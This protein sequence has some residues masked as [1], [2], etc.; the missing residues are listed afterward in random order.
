LAS[1]LSQGEARKLDW[2]SGPGAPML[3]DKATSGRCAVVGDGMAGRFCDVNRGDLGPIETRRLGRPRATWGND[4]VGPGVRA[5]IVAK[6]PGNSGGAKA[7]AGRW[8]RED[9]IQGRTTGVS[10]SCRDQ[11]SRRDPDPLGLDRT[12][13]M[14][15]SYAHRPRTGGERRQVSV[16]TTPTFTAK[17][18]SRC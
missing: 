6:K 11:A 1:L 7:W 4:R 13:D 16:G 2:A 17:G 8:M 9:Q 18:C 12:C 5:R 14:D 10:A 3:R 15:G